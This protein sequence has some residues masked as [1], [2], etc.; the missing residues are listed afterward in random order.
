MES[1]F[2]FCNWKTTATPTGVDILDHNPG[3]LSVLAYAS[4]FTLWHYRTSWT[5]RAVTKPGYFNGSAH[6]LRTGDMILAT[7]A[8][9]GALFMSQV[10]NDGTVSVSN[11]TGPR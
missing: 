7:M 11:L 9:S 5:E 6:M 2:D 3:N 1:H 10:T 8:N 4:N